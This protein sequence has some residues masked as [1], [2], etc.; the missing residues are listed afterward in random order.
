VGPKVAE[1]WSRILQQVRRA[2]LVLRYKGLHD[3]ALA[4]RYAAMFAAHGIAHDR[5]DFLGGSSHVDWLVSYQAV[6]IALDPFPFNG[7]LTT[8]EALWM[9]V[10][11]ITWPGETF[12]GRH[13]LTH[14][15]NVGLT[16]TI[17]RSLDDYVALA[18]KYA[19]DQQGLAV[20]RAGLRQRMAWSPL[21]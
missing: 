16:Q 10:P 8:C 17:A 7:G 14:L 18:V 1:A 21:C 2:R 3:P 4:S 19:E 5:V 9:G 6:D 15:S 12:A 20:L 11:V 13:G